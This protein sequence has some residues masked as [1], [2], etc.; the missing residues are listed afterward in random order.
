[1]G[2]YYSGSIEGKFWFALQSSDAAD[3]FGVIG[4]APS[5]ISYY[6]D[7]DNLEDVNKE[8]ANIEESLGDK[9]KI[10]DDFFEKSAG[11]N[12]AMML[13]IGI[14]RD[15]LKDYADLDL[16]KKIRDCIIENGDCSFDA[17]L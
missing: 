5:V 15:D 12:D 14:S 16:G 2:R 11:Y 3:R 10:I 17:E 4:E 7:E 8:I 13:E 1:M 9:I 6:Y